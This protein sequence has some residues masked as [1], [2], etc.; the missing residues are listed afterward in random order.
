M[1]HV[2][3]SII[4]LAP[5]TSDLEMSTPYSHGTIY[6]GGFL[7]T[8][9]LLSSLSSLNYYESLK[10]KGEEEERRDHFDSATLSEHQKKI[11]IRV[12]GKAV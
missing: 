3:F 2:I 6:P 8:S 1:K 12:R 10:G 7:L 9:L 4:F 11:Q 5:P